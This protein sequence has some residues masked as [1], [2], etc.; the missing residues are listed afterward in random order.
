MKSPVSISWRRGVVVRPVGPSRA[1][2]AAAHRP[3][4]RRPTPP[5]VGL[6][7]IPSVQFAPFYRAD[8]QGDYRDAGLDVTMQ[9]QIDG[10]C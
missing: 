5:T 1:P 10:S 3:T 2:L 7:Y 8:K 4:H 9:N 6:G